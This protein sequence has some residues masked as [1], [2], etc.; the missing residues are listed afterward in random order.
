MAT[1]R[2]EVGEEGIFEG[3]D[4]RAD[5][6]G[7]HHIA[8]K[9]CGRIREIAIQ[10]CP[11]FGASLAVA[12]AHLITPLHG[13]ASLSNVGTNTIH[14]VID[15]HAIGHRPFMSILHPQLAIEKA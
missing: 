7:S 1:A 6:V 15:V 3:A 2:K 11:T 9:L 8:V 4:D 5:L 10:L 13:A 14:L 12:F